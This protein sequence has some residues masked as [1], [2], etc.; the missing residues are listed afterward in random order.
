[1]LGQV[2]VGTLLGAV[3]VL[4]VLYKRREV[5]AR[6]RGEGPDA[7]HAPAPRSH[8]ETAPDWQRFDLITRAA[9][10]I[11][12]GHD[13]TSKATAALVVVVVLAE[14]VLDPLVRWIVLATVGVMVMISV[15]GMRWSRKRERTRARSTE[16]ARAADG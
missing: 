16:T 7:C 4:G 1:M 15:A 10:G 14:A 3:S 6:R 12:R 13:W 8:G 11:V 5:R 2:L 9:R